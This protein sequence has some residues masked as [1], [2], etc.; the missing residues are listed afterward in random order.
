MS[1]QLAAMTRRKVSNQGCGRRRR[2]RRSAGLFAGEPSFGGLVTGA[3]LAQR[4]RCRK[5]CAARQRSEVRYGSERLQLALYRSE[6]AHRLLDEEGHVDD[7]EDREDDF[8]VAREAWAL[9]EVREP[10]GTEDPEEQ[11]HDPRR[12]V[13]PLERGGRPWREHAPPFCAPRRERS[14]GGRR[15]ASARRRRSSSVPMARSV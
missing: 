10:K 7:H 12:A 3:I 9:P 13:V 15:T 8:Q 6:D 1:T 11:E 2:G 4:C 14:S 5:V